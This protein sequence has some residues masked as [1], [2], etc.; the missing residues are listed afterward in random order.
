MDPAFDDIQTQP[1]N[2]IFRVVF[3]PDRIYHARYLSATRSPRY[4]YD[5]DEVRNGPDILAAKGSVYLDGRRFAGVLR[6]EYRAG[7][8]VELARE[9]GRTL[10]MSIN[11]WTRVHPADT[12]LTADATVTARYDPLVDAYAVE[13]WDTLEPPDGTSHDHRVLPLMGAN[14]PITRPPALAPALADIRGVR[15]LELAFS[16]VG[17]ASPTGALLPDVQWDNNFLRSYQ[18]PNTPEPSSSQN[19]VS[20]LNYLLDYQR[21]FFF[22]NA[23]DTLPV[24]YRN[25]MM[26][27]DNPDAVPGDANVLEMRWLLQRELGGD[28]VFFHEVTIPP[29]VVEGTHRHIGSE[30]L[31]Y[32]VSGRG[33]VY[34][35]VDDDPTLASAPTVTKQI[36]GIGSRPCREVSVGPG[37]TLLTKSGGIHGIRNDGDEPLKFVAFLYQP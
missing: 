1:E 19:T 34:L 22:P 33:R 13:M 30:E 14:A 18:A 8:L 31:Y 9:R 12:S 16:E 2:E 17:R 23:S 5:V 26:D 27:E 25:A 7:R 36:Y 21:A 28:L 4:R 29:G 10:G 15:R 35:G 20:V 32:V 11:V 24:R 6:V 3:F 37:S